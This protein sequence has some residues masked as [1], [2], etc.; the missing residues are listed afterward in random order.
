MFFNYHLCE[1]G[2]SHYLCLDILQILEGYV[3]SLY[4]GMNEYRFIIHC[5]DLCIE[6]SADFILSSER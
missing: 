4:K 5:L 2:I 3:N 1:I 6:S